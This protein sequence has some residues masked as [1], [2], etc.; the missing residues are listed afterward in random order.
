[1]R[2][3]TRG[4]S[5]HDGAH[6][7]TRTNGFSSSWRSSPLLVPSN[8]CPYCSLAPTQICIPRAQQNKRAPH[9]STSHLDQEVQ[10]QELGGGG[11]AGLEVRRH[12]LPC[13]GPHIQGNQGVRPGS[14]NTVK[15]NNN[16]NTTT[17]IEAGSGSNPHGRRVSGCTGG[18][19][20]VGRRRG[21]N[22]I[23]VKG[24]EVGEQQECSR[25]WARHKAHTMHHRCTAVA[26]QTTQSATSNPSPA[27]YRTIFARMGRSFE[28]S[29]GR[30]NRRLTARGMRICPRNSTCQAQ[31]THVGTKPRSCLTLN[32][33]H[34]DIEW[35]VG[36]L[37]PTLM[38]VIFRTTSKG[39]PRMARPRLTTL[40]PSSTVLASARQ[41][42]Q[43]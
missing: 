32:V 30:G 17:T 38:S 26:E 9:R 40:S 11:H 21:G 8:T 27:A 1:M 42:E 5:T 4:H 14:H 36:C 16:N 43:T 10:V 3:W 6:L 7:A 2:W 12:T 41:E 37:L 18:G 22:G 13:F 34:A 25:R 20:G 24:P 28:S 29:N 35:G 15:D 23:V 33:P 39:G 19:V 31:Y